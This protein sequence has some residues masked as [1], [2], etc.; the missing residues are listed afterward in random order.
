MSLDLTFTIV[1]SAEQGTGISWNELVEEEELR[2]P[3]RAVQMHE[4]LSSPSRKRF[5][6]YGIIIE[7]I[8]LFSN[9]IFMKQLQCKSRA[10]VL[11]IFDLA[12]W[13]F[14]TRVFSKGSR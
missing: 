6:C 5:D 7:V 4:K 13:N 11:L 1:I 9:Q 14:I 2:E 10:Q 8:D 3:G 12:L